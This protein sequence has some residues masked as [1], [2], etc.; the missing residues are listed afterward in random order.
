VGFPDF[1][2]GLFEAGEVKMMNWH[3]DT[4]KDSGLSFVDRLKECP[5]EPDPLVYAARMAAA[6]VIR[7]S[8]RTCNRFEITGR[9]RLPQNGSFV[10]VANHA[11]HLDAVALLCALPLRSLHR[12]YPLAARDYFGANRVRLA[13]TAI[14]AN[15]MLFDRDAAG[16]QTLK[17]CQQMLEK[18]GNVLVMFP[19]GTRSIDGRIGVFRRG[20]GLLLAGPQH[21]V[22]PCHLDGTFEAWPK[23][24]L[25]PR[26]ARVRLA[27]GEP[28]TYELVKQ[29]DAGALHICADLRAAVL[30]LASE[31]WPQTARP[32]SQEAYQ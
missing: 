24:S 21:P 31:T 14:I 15:V 13:L 19:E 6:V 23:G 2:H 4:A 32:V 29:N 5:R 8:L 25:I 7:A 3:Y 11:S 22:V 27:I 10:L 1:S 26:P 9:E 30:A 28:R 16:R 20:V 18:R 12:A 17:L